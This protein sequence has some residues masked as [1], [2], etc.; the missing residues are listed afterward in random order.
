MSRHFERASAPCM[1]FSISSK[2]VQDQE[3]RDWQ[4]RKLY[5]GAK[6]ARVQS[7]RGRAHVATLTDDKRKGVAAVE[8]HPTTAHAKRKEWNVAP[9]RSI[10]ALESDRSE[11]KMLHQLVER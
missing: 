9:Q 1:A 2:G 8:Q 3:K 11:R 7:Y 10:L 6:S 5:E 4:N